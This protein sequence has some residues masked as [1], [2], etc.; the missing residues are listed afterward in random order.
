MK[1][2]RSLIPLS[3]QHHN[4][5]AL[6]VLTDRSLAED[7][8]GENLCRLSDKV[9]SRYEI[10]LINHFELEEK[11]LF[12]A[13][14]ESLA[15]LVKELTA[16]H[17][18]TERLVAALREEASASLLESFTSLLRRHIR[19][20]ENELFEQ[21]QALLP[22]RELDRLGAEFERQAVRVCLEP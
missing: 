5:L 18:E 19:R 10:E 21:V 2:D 1:R 13:C 9:V 3:H 7:G 20:E 4:G 11:L 14:P 16:E 22:R 6:C 15:P 12:P 8:S 17:R